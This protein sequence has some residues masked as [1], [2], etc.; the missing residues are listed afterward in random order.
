MSRTVPSPAA[1][2]DV[3]AGKRVP[4]HSTAVLALLA[5]GVVYGDIGTSPLYAAKETFNPEHGIPLTPDNIFGGVSAIFWSLM[6][7]VS[8]KYVLLVMRASNRGEGGIMALLALATA[9]VGNRARLR[10]ALLAIGVFGAALFY[11]D[12]VLTPAISVLSAVEGLEVGT[13]ALKPYI[14]PI[15][16]GILIA[17]FAIQHYGTGIVGLLFGPI[18]ALWF[19]S[20]GAVGAWNVIQE[21]T[22]IKAV[23]PRYA[24]HFATAH[25]VASFVVLGSVLLAVTG[26]EALYADMGHFGKRAI[27]VAW[28]AVVAPGLVLNYFGQGALLIARPEALKNPF[29]LSYPDWALYP[30]IV[31]ATAATVIASQATISGAYSMTQQAIQLGYLPRLPIRHTS[32]R[33]IGQIYVPAVNWILLVAV[34]AAVI[35][36]GSSSRLGSAYGVAVMGT[37]LVTTLLTFFVLRYGWRYPL[38]LCVPATAF[39]ALI[40]LVFFAAAMHKVLDGGWFPLAMGAIVFTIMVTWRR[41]R[42]MLHTQLVGSSPP[43]EGFLQ[44]L[45][46]SPP[47]RVPGTAVFLVSTPDTTPNAL[48]HSL[49]HYKVLHEQNVFMTVIFGD[50]PF[51]EPEH[52]IDCKRLAHDCWQV[53][54]RYGFMETPDVALVLELCAQHGLLVE[55]MDVTYFLSREK[56]VP[57]PSVEGVALWRDKFFAA[58][59]RNAGDVTDFFNIPA[60][61][62]VELG[63]RIEI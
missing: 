52:R 14:V 29:Y 53:I 9:A 1:V 25:G 44:S 36:F 17:L 37:M 63:T 31:L 2:D 32:A 4:K 48:L 43:L 46:M 30:M 61:R 18:C 8:L 41:G 62:V 45:F 42:E 38:W 22:I 27:R 59:A 54:A 58:M 33:A 35:G 7:I 26:A 50:V 49:K 15:S 16:A 34:S 6:I 13:E 12:A 19:I 40:D 10:A 23:D 60:N 56:V 5:L 55:S 11:G 39:F 28:F 3:V 24:V 57:G 47:Q 51:V 21:P 20:I